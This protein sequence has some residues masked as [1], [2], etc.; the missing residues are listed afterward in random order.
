MFI[1]LL[2][3]W[4]ENG[5]SF[6]YKNLSRTKYFHVNSRKCHFTRPL[7]GLLGQI[8]GSH[9]QGSLPACPSH[10]L[11]KSWHLPSPQLCF[12]LSLLSPRTGYSACFWCVGWGEGRPPCCAAAEWGSPH[13]ER[14]VAGRCS[15]WEAAPALCDSLRNAAA[16]S[17]SHCTCTK[18]IHCKTLTWHLPARCL[19]GEKILNLAAN[20]SLVGLQLQ[21]T[22]YLSA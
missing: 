8:F 9:E 13:G 20:P 3:V 12:F 19:K 16:R 14:S 4:K 2:L 7:T 15:S 17:P 10:Q 11:I 6:P 18:V 21:H 22:A 1:S 5:W